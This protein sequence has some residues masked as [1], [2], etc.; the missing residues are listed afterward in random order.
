MSSNSRIIMENLLLERFTIFTSD[1]TERTDIENFNN[2][3]KIA[4]HL[5]KKMTSHDG[6]L[7]EKHKTTM[8][9]IV[10]RYASDNIDT[11]GRQ[12]ME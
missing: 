11:W 3:Q 1:W 8:Q 7:L 12:F 5:N 4:D 6:I 2:A 10:C 9:D